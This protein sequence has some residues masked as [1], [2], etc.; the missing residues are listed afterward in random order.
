MTASA[1][2]SPDKTPTQTT[3]TAPILVLFPHNP[4]R[5]LYVARYL[6]QNDTAYFALT[7]VQG[8]YQQLNTAILNTLEEQGYTVKKVKA[9]NT[10]E[11]AG[12]ALGQAIAGMRTLILD[13][14]DLFTGDSTA[15]LRG[16]ADGIGGKFQVVVS[17]RNLDHTAMNPLLHDK[18]AAVIEEDTRTPEPTFNG[19][20]HQLSV[21]ALGIGSVWFE[22][23]LITHW[24]GPLT[25]RLFYYLL[26]RGPVSRAQIFETFWP[27]L[28]IREA[29][30]VFHVTK[31]KMNETI[32]IDVT[33]Y[34]DR[35]Y[36]IADRV[37][38]YYDVATFEK[39]LSEAE[40]GYG[41]E[42]NASWDR[43]IAIYRHQFLVTEA[44]PWVINRRQQLRE[45]YA[46][47]LI[48]MG[49]TYLKNNDTV[50]ALNHFLRAII[51]V[52]MREDLHL[53]VMRLQADSGNV[54]AALA[55]YEL[56]ERRLRETLNI[57]PGKEAQQLYAR[58]KR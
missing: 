48:S 44:M 18:V 53:Q 38:L 58:L 17:A 34:V 40:E 5:N 46:Q 15:W 57:R 3:P 11:E 27:N 10:P 33:D 45:G 37:R 2:L 29:T 25:R 6:T 56:L 49:R 28:P 14:F 24:D 4:A 43:A 47:A 1:L 39:A 21:R 23:S 50:R 16:L 32:G 7:S 19:E 54:S 51:E 35:H 12:R 42:S 41:D 13:Q 30:N 26:D 31:R 55:Q 52:P 8:T 9:A 20:P 36:R 22:G